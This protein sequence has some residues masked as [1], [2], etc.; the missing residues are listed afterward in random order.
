[1]SYYDYL[2]PYAN[3]QIYACKSCHKD[4]SVDYLD[5]CVPIRLAD[6]SYKNEMCPECYQG[7]EAN[8][9]DN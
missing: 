6:K 7:K 2:S 5:A 3:A 1:M 4:V 9:K 8:E